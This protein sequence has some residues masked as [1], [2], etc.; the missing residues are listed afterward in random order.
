MNI[1]KKTFVV[2]FAIFIISKAFG[3]VLD[4]R[5]QLTLG[6]TIH[7]NHNVNG[8][9]FRNNFSSIKAFVGF[10]GTHTLALNKHNEKYRGLFNYGIS[11]TIYN[12]S[13]GNSLNILYQDNQIDFTTSA[14]LGL[15]HNP[16][17]PFFKQLQT[18]NNTPFYNLRHSAQNGVFISSN[19]ILNNNRRHQTIG[20]LTATAG[21]VSVNYYNDGGPIIGKGFKFD[22]KKWYTYLLFPLHLISGL[23]DGFDRW[24]TGGGGVYIHTKEGFNRLEV[25]FDQFTGYHKLAYE[26]SGIFGSDVQDYD[27][28][29]EKTEKDTSSTSAPLNYKTGKSNPINYNSSTY[30]VRYFFD[31]DLS[32]NM[33]IIGSLRDYKR[34]RYYAFQDIIHLLRRDP[35]HPNNDINRIYYGLSYYKPFTIR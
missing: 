24:W 26:L 8:E 32:V 25:T 23:G 2:F 31:S 15:L 21:P 4:E 13:L 30:G 11:F 9:S 35:I 6:A 18:I 3:Q 1:T 22:P 16:N 20:S 33:G 28:F 12:R 34:E 14:T 29:Q 17:Q 27:L 10:N 19:F 5:Y 7:L